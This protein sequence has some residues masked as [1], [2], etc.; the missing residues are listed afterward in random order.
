MNINRRN[1]IT[2]A[3]IAGGSAVISPLSSCSSVGKSESI[4]TDYKK[5]IVTC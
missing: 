4:K 2:T 3:A 1:F 5:G